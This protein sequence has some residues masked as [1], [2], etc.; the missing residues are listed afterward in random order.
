MDSFVSVSYKTEIIRIFID[1]K[2]TASG[3]LKFDFF[4]K[5]LILFMILSSKVTI[6]GR[7]EGCIAT[8]ICFQKI[9]IC[10]KKIEVCKS[11]KHMQ[12]SYPQFENNS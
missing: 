4:F 11:R 7:V 9:N 10:P 8:L 5:I 2:D 12:L 6:N 3:T 1:M